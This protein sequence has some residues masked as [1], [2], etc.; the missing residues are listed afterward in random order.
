ML[1][2][3]EADTCTEPSSQKIHAAAGQ[4]KNFSHYFLLLALH[5]LHGIWLQFHTG[6]CVSAGGHTKEYH[7]GC[8]L[9]TIEQRKADQDAQD[10]HA[11]HMCWANPT[12]FPPQ[13]I[14]FG[15]IIDF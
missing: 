6:I 4:E 10:S 5:F 9:K 12:H 13:E 11:L 14:Q 7:L 3:W 15:N 1:I 8:F 2:S